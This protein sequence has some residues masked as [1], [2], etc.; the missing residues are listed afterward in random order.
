MYTTIL[1]VHLNGLEKVTIAIHI[2][3]VCMYSDRYIRMLEGSYGGYLISGAIQY[4]SSP[5]ITPVAQFD[6]TS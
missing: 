3:Y 4:N 6:I 5:R 1:Y 2:M